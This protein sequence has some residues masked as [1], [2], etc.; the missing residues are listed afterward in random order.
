MPFV[1]Y[2]HIVQAM[3]TTEVTEQHFEAL[4]RIYGNHT[5]AAK[6]LGVTQRHY[7]Y[8]RQT[9]KMS[10]PLRILILSKTELPTE[11]QEGHPLP[12]PPQPDEAAQTQGA[13]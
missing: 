3:K 12:T 13:A 2:S 1:R 4:H 6:A 8:V 5:E 9:R 7:A 10:G 11:N